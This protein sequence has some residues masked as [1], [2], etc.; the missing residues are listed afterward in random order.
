[1]GPGESMIMQMLTPLTIYNNYIWKGP[2]GPCGRRADRVFRYSFYS[3]SGK[4]PGIGSPARP[5]KD[6]FYWFT[7]RKTSIIRK[8]TIINH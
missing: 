1:M 4:R 6:K 3:D 5:N 2:P 7:K 8:E